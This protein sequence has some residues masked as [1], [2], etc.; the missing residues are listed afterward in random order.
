MLSIIVPVLNQA[1]MTYDCLQAVMENTED[2]EIIVIDNGSDPPFRP[3]FAGF[4]EIQVIRNEENKGFPEAVNQGIRAAKGDVIILLNNDVTVS[5]GTL[6][7]LVDWL[8]T[9][10]IVG[11]TTNYCAGMQMVQIPPYQN[12]EELDK[13]V[14]A[15]FESS[16]GE[17]EEVNWIIGFCMAFKKSVWKTVGDFDTT[18]WPCNGEEIDFCLKAK[19]KGFKVGIAWDIYVHH[20]GSVTFRD[21]EDAGQLEYIKICERNDKHLAEKWGADFWNRQ[22]LDTEIGASPKPGLNLNLGSGYRPLEGFVN[23]DNRAEVKPDLVC[24]VTEGLPYPDNSVDMV[25]AHDFLEHIPIGKTI[26]VMNEIW[27]VLKP[28]GL[29]DSFTPSTDGRGAFQD[30]TH[31]SFWNQNSWLYYSDP[32]HR[33]LYGTIADFKLEKIEDITLDDPTIIY[34]HVIAKAR[35]ELIEKKTMKIDGPLRLNL[36]CGINKLEGFVNI[37]Q[38]Q[39]IEFQGKHTSP[40]LVADVTGGLPYDYDSV[41]EIYCGH[42]LEHMDWNVG[43]IALRYWLSLL[44]P[45]GIIGITVPNFDIL[46]ERY[47]ADPTPLAMREMNEFYIFS[48]IQPSHHKYAYGE[49]LLKA[50]MEEAGFIDLERLPV[51]D[52]H[53]YEAADWQ[54]GYKGVKPK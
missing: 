43:Q 24:D 22:V 42:L 33:K 48:Y 7:H 20:E 16:Q 45:G 4:N 27:R 54:I 19:E 10:D 8:D 21:M 2:A 28:G 38:F 41:D 39:D 53:F 25:R 47:L 6:N 13:E 51:D 36:G 5:P 9:F 46:A 29:F 12:R 32:E 26:G 31:M 18:L 14:E 49:S 30:P 3:P 44:K 35:K 15:L 52:P 34:T 37:D 11:P 23:I 1:E 40:D 17:A 50:A